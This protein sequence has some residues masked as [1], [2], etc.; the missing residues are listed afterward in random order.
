MRAPRPAR[1]GGFRDGDRPA[2]Q[3][4]EARVA[5]ALRE[6]VTAQSTRWVTEQLMEHDVSPAELAAA[7]YQV[8]GRSPRA[9]P[10]TDAGGFTARQAPR[11]RSS[12]RP[13]RSAPAFG[14]PGRPAA[15]PRAGAPGRAEGRRTGEG[16]DGADRR[17]AGPRSTAGR[18][19][20]AWAGPGVEEAP[21]RPR[22]KGGPGARRVAASTPARGPRKDRPGGITG[23][24]RGAKDRED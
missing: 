12:E 1:A 17:P 21:P 4:L 11:E 20:G 5:R 14:A 3:P 9:R 22:V 16:R 6:G 19:G 18:A 24:A 23:F 10:T 8:L 7:I 13:S 2:P 15:R